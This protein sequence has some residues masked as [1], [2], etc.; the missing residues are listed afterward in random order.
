MAKQTKTILLQILI[1]LCINSI[2]SSADPEPLDLN[3][4]AFSDTIQVQNALNNSN[5]II[6]NYPDIALEQL[7]VLKEKINA[8]PYSP[9]QKL[10][11]I[12]I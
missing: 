8:Y 1:L 4:I 12:M 5:K 3:K 2:S 11:W 6:K 9:L 7:K 10:K